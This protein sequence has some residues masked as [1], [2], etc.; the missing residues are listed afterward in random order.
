MAAGTRSDA[1]LPSDAGLLDRCIARVEHIV[2]STNFQFMMWRL[3]CALRTRGAHELEIRT[4]RCRYCYRNWVDLYPPANRTQDDER[5]SR[6]V[7][8]T[9]RVTPND[10]I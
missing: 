4:A 9:R 3:R 10:S 6:P 1:P 2:N 7:N 8:E 5:P